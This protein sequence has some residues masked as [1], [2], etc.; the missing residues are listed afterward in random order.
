MN[1]RRAILLA[2]GR[3]EVK[4][5]KKKSGLPR[6]TAEKPSIFKGF[7]GKL[8]LPHGTKV[9][10]LLHT[11]EVTGSSPVVSTI[12]EKS[13][14]LHNWKCVRIFYLHQR[15]YILIDKAQRTSPPSGLFLVMCRWFN[16]AELNS[17]CC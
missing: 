4:T 14:L 15:H 9:P 8:L 12:H 17:K 5:A 1:R 7:R 11:H 3:H 6:Q 16:L 2:A 13:E 10:G